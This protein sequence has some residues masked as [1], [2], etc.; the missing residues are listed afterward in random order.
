MTGGFCG[1]KFEEKRLFLYGARCV[2]A[3]ANL[4]FSNL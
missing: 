3:I 1:A 2:E 4:I